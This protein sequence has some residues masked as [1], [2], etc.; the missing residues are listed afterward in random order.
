MPLQALKPMY[1]PAWSPKVSSRLMNNI[2]S[3]NQIISPSI[4]GQW[5]EICFTLH[6]F[7]QK[8][9]HGP[10]SKRLDWKAL[11]IHWEDLMLAAINYQTGLPATCRHVAN[12]NVG[13]ARHMASY[14]LNLEMARV[15][16]ELKFIQRIGCSGIIHVSHV[17]A[18]TK[19]GCTR[20]VNSTSLFRKSKICAP[21]AKKRWLF[22]GQSRTNSKKLW[23]RSLIQK[24]TK[25]ETVKQPQN[26]SPNSFKSWSPRKSQDSFQFFFGGTPF[27]SNLLNLRCA[28][29]LLLGTSMPYWRLWWL[30][31]P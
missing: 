17:L 1:P 27:K 21:Q 12:N 31:L 8:K 29:A 19:V 2:K 10:A 18:C 24:K 3:N 6:V 20:K 5:S 14:G 26:K 15:F 28:L 4:T 13:H 7:K 11:A 30:S 23:E 9:N 16:W 22:G 25:H